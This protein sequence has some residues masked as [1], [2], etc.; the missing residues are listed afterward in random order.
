MSCSDSEKC[1]KQLKLGRTQYVLCFGVLGWGIPV[2]ILFS[3]IQGYRLGWDE[4]V[5]GLIPALIIFPLAGIP[6]GLCMWKLF[7]NKNAKAAITGSK[8]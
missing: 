1:D 7:Q 5:S 3:L 2:A 8:E 4:F 6:F